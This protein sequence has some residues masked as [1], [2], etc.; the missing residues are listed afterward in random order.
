MWVPT[1][2]W[3]IAGGFVRAMIGLRKALAEKRKVRWGLFLLTLGEAVVLG[4]V[5]G[6]LL[7]EYNPILNFFVG[8]GGTYLIDNAY[9]LIKFASVKIPVK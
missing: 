6:Y 8:L 4:A 7:R 9:R 1:V 3:S 5:F 2:G